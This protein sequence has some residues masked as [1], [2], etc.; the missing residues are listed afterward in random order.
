MTSAEFY[1]TVTPRIKYYSDRCGLLRQMSH[2]AWSLCVSCALTTL[3]PFG[4]WLLWVQETMYYY[5]NR[6]LPRY[7]AM[8]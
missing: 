6:D 8:T 1:F 5:V 4:G 7:L 2:V 3:M